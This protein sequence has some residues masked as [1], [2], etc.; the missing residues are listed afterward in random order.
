MR[1]KKEFDDECINSKAFRRIYKIQEC[2]KDGKCERCPWHG[3]VDNTNPRRPK[4]DRYKDL[5][6]GKI[7]SRRYK[8]APYSCS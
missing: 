7:R 8:V 2:Q 5:R 1:I 4:D 3:G 6:K